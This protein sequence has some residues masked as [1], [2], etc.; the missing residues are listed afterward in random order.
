[1]STKQ[2]VVGVV[3]VVAIIV[4]VWY[5]MAGTMKPAVASGHP[6]WPPIMYQNGDVIDGAGPALVKKIFTDLGLSVSFPATGA[7][8]VVQSKAKS[9]EVDI[10]VAAYKT[11]ARLEYMNYSEE[12]TT[13]PIVLFVAKG[14][15]F[16]FAKWDDLLNK[17]GVAMTGDSYGQEFDTY[18]AEKLHFTHVDTTQE[19]LDM[20]KN[21]QADYFIYSLYAGTVML[22]K[23]NQADQF[24][25][26]PTQVAAE[27]F[28]ITI[29][30]KSPYV[31]YM[32][33]INA[34]IQ[35]YRADG[36]IDALVEQ[37][38]KH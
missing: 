2:I 15:T 23:T 13:D 22:G 8:D 25:S 18:S 35:K 9:G 34:A 26:L 4:G 6:E 33:Q 11:D 16:Q 19:A 5:A 36:T 27:H 31:K 20:V 3:L 14:K 12:Y 37:Y 38:K 30:K 10:L 7:W 32:P 28:Y 29:S 17:K 1:M 21:G 24:E